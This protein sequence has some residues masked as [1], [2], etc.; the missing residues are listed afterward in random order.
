MMIIERPQ[1]LKRINE[2]HK[3]VFIY[4]RRKTGKTFLVQNFIKYDEYFFVKADRNILSKENTSLTYETFIEILKI[5]LENGKT[6]VVDEFH[7]LGEAFFDF[8]HFTP[9]KG[10]LIIISSTLF[11]SKKLLSGKSSLLGLFAEVSIGLIALEDTLAYVR[12]F[13]F[14]KKEML[15]LAI[16]LREPLAVDYFHEKSSARETL[17]LILLSSLKTIPALIGEIFLEEEREISAIYEGIVRAIA[18]GKGNSGEI[19]SY[20]FSKKLLEK[21]DPSVLQQY[22]VNLISFGIIK[23]IEV[24]HKK[25]FVYKLV[26]PLARIY[27]YADEKYNI[28]ERKISY[29]EILP[30][31]NEIMPRIIEDTVREALAERYGLRE[32]ILESKD[33]D[34]DGYLL[35]FKKPVIALEVKWG[36]L[37]KEDIALI[38]KNLEAQEAERKILFVQDKERIKSTLEVLD[39]EDLWN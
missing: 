29:G 27:Y 14:T 20:I 39:V 4:G 2:L 8:L 25:R 24:F 18:V 17:A 36:K 33:F 32:S 12:T 22:L 30:I 37:R 9:K 6:V 23:R 26:S 21:D 34:I 35:R 38:K 13:T 16:L 19:S 7:R 3:W 5:T 31:L 15:E 1:E 28:S 10:K 11:L